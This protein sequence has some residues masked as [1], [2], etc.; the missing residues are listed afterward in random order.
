M[1]P[2]RI[3]DRI[4]NPHL[5]RFVAGLRFRKRIVARERRR[6]HCFRLFESLQNSSLTAPA[7]ALLSITLRM[8]RI[9][10]VASRGR[11]A[12]SDQE[13]ELS[14]AAWLMR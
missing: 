7:N 14:F 6:F 4:E 3:I 5:Q 12:P 11:D 2:A 8:A 9:E 10:L 1:V 13:R